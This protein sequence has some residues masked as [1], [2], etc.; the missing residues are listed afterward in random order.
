M[1]DECLPYNEIVEDGCRP[2]DE[3][4]LN[5]T[6][7]TNA[8]AL[9]LNDTL[10]NTVM[11]VKLRDADTLNIDDVIAT[12]DMQQLIYDSILANVTDINKEIVDVQNDTVVTKV[13][14]ES[15][16]EEVTKR[17]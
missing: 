8:L 14:L 17:D 5:L 9:Q 4:V 16:Q 13:M 7:A 11:A 1:C 15:Q 6:D 2:C 10:F 3:C 12:I